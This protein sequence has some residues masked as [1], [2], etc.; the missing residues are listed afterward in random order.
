MTTGAVVL[1]FRLLLREQ[2][3]FWEKSCFDKL[4]LVIEEW[5]HDSAWLYLNLT[6]DQ[7]VSFLGSCCFGVFFSIH[8]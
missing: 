3:R 7:F 5:V 8:I 4:Y 1:A 6:L 2:I